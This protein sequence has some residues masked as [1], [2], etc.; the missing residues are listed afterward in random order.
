M[1][2]DIIG[3]WIKNQWDASF[4]LHQDWKGIKKV[5]LFVDVLVLPVLAF[6]TVS[7]R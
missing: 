4:N 3:E 2:T 6:G 7:W 1:N 5:T